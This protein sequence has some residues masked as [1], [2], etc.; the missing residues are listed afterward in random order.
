MERVTVIVPPQFMVPANH[1]HM[2]LGKSRNLNT[3]TGTKLRKDGQEYASSSGLWA[4]RQT[5]GVENPELIGELALAG[6]VPDGVSLEQA[7]IAQAAFALVR[8]QYDENGNAL[9]WPQPDPLRIMAYIGD[10]PLQLFA[11]LGL[12]SIN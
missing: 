8:R 6:R 9:P 7:A 10:N 11:D 5:Q 4:E 12:E 1:V 2:L 3:Y